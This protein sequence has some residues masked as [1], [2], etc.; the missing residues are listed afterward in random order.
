MVA[1]AGVLAGTPLLPRLVSL[2][3]R[4]PI[5][6]LVYVLCLD[7]KNVPQNEFLLLA[8][9]AEPPSPCACP[10]GAPVLLA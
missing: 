5:A 3:L 8:P 1:V 10:I 4:S 9:C 7:D 6:T 2:P